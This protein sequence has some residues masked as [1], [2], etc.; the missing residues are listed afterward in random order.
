MSV[1]TFI[2]SDGPLREVAPQNGYPHILNIDE[3]TAAVCDGGADGNFFLYKFP[4]VRK[5]SDKK[6]GVYLE[7]WQYTDGRAK[8]I[9][10]YIKNALEYESAIEIWHVWLADYYEYEESPVIRK[11][12]VPFSDVTMDDIKE[13]DSAEIWNTPDKRNPGRPSF[14]CLIIER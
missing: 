9:L 4:D 11:C 14:Y 10:E 5:Y 3:G 13:I 8:K 12:T 7:W 6:Y 2:A 1:C